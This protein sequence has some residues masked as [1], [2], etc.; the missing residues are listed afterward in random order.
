[1]NKPPPVTCRCGAQ[2]ADWRFTS[3]G[4]WDLPKG[5][6][7]QSVIGGSFKRYVCGDCWERWRRAA[8]WETAC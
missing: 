3:T 6:A 7:M 4:H 1:M 5:W 2:S 8:G